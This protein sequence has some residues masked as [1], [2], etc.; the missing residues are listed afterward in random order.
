MVLFWENV[1]QLEV[2]DLFF[3]R[4]KSLYFIIPFTCLRVIFNILYMARVTVYI[5]V[6]QRAAQLCYESVT[7]S[8]WRRKAC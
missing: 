1:S 8:H 7:T 2:L 3:K 5:V 4:Y 6:I